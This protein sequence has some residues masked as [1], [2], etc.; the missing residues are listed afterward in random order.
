MIAASPSRSGLGA[1][2]NALIVFIVRRSRQQSGRT[3]E[4]DNLALSFNEQLQPGYPD[5][6]LFEPGHA[7][8]KGLCH[9]KQPLRNVYAR[10]LV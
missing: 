2:N 4:A 8:V 1:R 6:K 3:D 10:T 9:S 5:L 7:V